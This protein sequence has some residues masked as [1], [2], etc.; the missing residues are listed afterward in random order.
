[1]A[2]IEE[3]AAKYGSGKV[4]VAPSTATVDP[5]AH[6]ANKYGSGATTDAPTPAAATYDPTQIPLSGA[7]PEQQTQHMEEVRN[8]S[9]SLNVNDRAPVV[10]T[11]MKNLNKGLK[12]SSDLMGEGVTDYTKGNVANAAGKF[13]LGAV[14]GAFNAAMVAPTINTAKDYLTKFTGNPEFSNRAELVA[15]GGLPIAKTAK[16]IS[17]LAPSSRA[18]KTIVDAV[19]PENLPTFI[20]KLKSNP[21]LTAMDVDPNVQ[22]IAQ[23]LAAKP[24]DPRHLL[25]KVVKGRNDTK[26]DTVTGAI[27]EAMG[28]PVNIT[29]K[30]DTLKSK[31]KAVGKEINPIVK[32][33]GA[34]DMSP[35]IASIDAKLKPG[36]NSVIS[37]GEPLPLGDIE[38]SLE[39]VKKL[40]TDG[41]SVRTDAQSLH[42][43]QSALRAK[44]EDLLSSTSGQDRQLG[45]ALMDVRNQ[46]VS[47]I[48]KAS[49]QTNTA[50]DYL[51]SKGFQNLDAMNPANLRLKGADEAII[52]QAEDAIKAYAT[53]QGW[54]GAS[55]SYKPA[56]A[57]YRDEND[58]ME[59][60]KKGTEVTKNR[61][62]NLED[63][64]TYWDKWVKSNE[65]H[66]EVLD[67]AREGARLAYAHQMGSVVNAAR[68]GMD[69]PA[70]QFNKEKLYSLFDKSE[71]DKMAK[72]LADEKLIADTNS[73]LFQGSM[74]AMRTLGNTATE[75]RAGYKP[76]Y[77][78]LLP[79]AAE[80]LNQYVSGGSLPVALAAGYGYMGLRKGMTAIG[81]KLDRKTNL[82]IADLATATGDAKEKLIQAL[83]NHIPRGKLTLAQKS[84]LAL[85]IAKP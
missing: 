38:K 25:D 58:I 77:S 66:P 72:A 17:D 30:I 73:K 8:P 78:N 36:V 42:N 69:I 50:F 80:G 18:V 60:F 83:Q 75:V 12:E 65:S 26:L 1:M 33:T 32:D 21:R 29:D 54:S 3:L 53:K 16:V 68:K 52:A 39:G 22:I 79:V 23:G 43:F 27:D 71:V 56:L 7:T 59:G 76:D 61:L 9:K 34:V 40:I 35:V 46:I 70:I 85:P 2:T 24:G 81:Q 63:D 82:E 64:P 28:V 31:I 49:P 14:G 84:M 74:T 4:V 13:I 48:D 47:A 41:K 19:G 51:K 55:G 44:A 15:T 37:V 20:Q 11:F 6:L 62:G 67:A 45:Y 57:K 10:N 5:Y